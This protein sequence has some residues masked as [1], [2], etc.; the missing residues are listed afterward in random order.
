M[1]NP[2]VA[3]IYVDGFNLYYRLRKT[4]YKWLDLRR[5]FEQLLP[6]YRVGHVHYCTARVKARPA[7]PYAPD[8][9]DAYL[10]ALATWPGLTIHYG[11]FQA[12]KTFARLVS[13][14]APPQAPT[15]EVHKT[16]EKG[17]DVNLGTLMLVDAY[18]SA[19]DVSV[20]VSNDSDLAMPLSVVA[21]RLGRAAVLVNPYDA[22]P[23]NKL[24]KQ[25][26]TGGTVR[27]L[28][29][30]LLAASQLPDPVVDLDGKSV[31]KPSTW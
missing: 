30:G 16:E 19:C 18:E 21:Q 28:R 6:S 20:L 17:S 31:M 4:P 26:G 23:N 5:L 1:P 2:P 22:N 14:P 10:R 29:A 3:N 9:Q 11:Q 25:M 7:D 24:W 8:R 13:P 27:R 12:T 15:V